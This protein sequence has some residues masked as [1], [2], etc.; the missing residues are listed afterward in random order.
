MPGKMNCSGV[1]LGKDFREIGLSGMH[2]VQRK[3][4]M[5]SF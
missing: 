5:C 1:L 3:A 4:D 2:L